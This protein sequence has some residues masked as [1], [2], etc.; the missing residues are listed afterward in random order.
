VQ[1]YADLIPAGPVLGRG[2]TEPSAHLGDVDPN[3]ATAL[4]TGCRAVRLDCSTTIESGWLPPKGGLG[5]SCGVLGMR[6][7]LPARA[8][9]A[10]VSAAETV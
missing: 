7:S 2:Q 1:Q 4:A 6:P 3:R 5:G 9:A 10:G 8:S